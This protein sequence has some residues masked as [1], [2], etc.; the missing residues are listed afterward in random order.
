MGE[1]QFRTEVECVLSVFF[2]APKHLT[3]LQ[4]EHK[5]EQEKR[6]I[7]SHSH[8]HTKYGIKVRHHFHFKWIRIRAQVSHSDERQQNTQMTTECVF[9]F[10]CLLEFLFLFGNNK[11]DGR[12]LQTHAFSI[13]IHSFVYWNCVK[14]D[15]E[16]HKDTF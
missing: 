10:S 8:L 6:R 2:N 1:V 15:K 13:S 16:Q 14:W 11:T 4:R 5:R 3:F 12:E 9:K 7:A